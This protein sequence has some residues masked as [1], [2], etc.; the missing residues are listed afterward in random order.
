VADQYRGAGPQRGGD[1][2]AK[3]APALYSIDD[4]L[5]TLEA[6]KRAGLERIRTL[7]KNIVPDAQEAI[8]YGMPT[9]TYQSK[10]F[11]G[12]N[13]H[14]HHIG[15]YPYSAEVIETL[16]DHL[17]AYGVSKGSIRVPLDRPIAEH[18]L[19]QVIECR[20]EQIRATLKGT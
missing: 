3:K 5:Q 16:K 9:L 20:L 19:R 2:A 12:F 18:T 4:Y 14:T 1:R 15:L 7:A 6:S 11:L 17:A 13:A 10:P 8:M